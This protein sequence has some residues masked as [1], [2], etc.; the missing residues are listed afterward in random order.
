MEIITALQSKAF[1][2]VDGSNGSSKLAR[3][4]GLQ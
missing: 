1:V 3:E 4:E 2:L